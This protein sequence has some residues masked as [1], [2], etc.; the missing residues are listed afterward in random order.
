MANDHYIP[1][2]LIGRFST[3]TAGRSRQRKI[4]AL[5]RDKQSVARNGKA[6][7]YG[8][9]QD[10]YDLIM[11]QHAHMPQVVDKTWL[12][13]EN[14]LGT[15]LDVLRATTDRYAIDAHSWLT[16]L[17][18]FVASLFVRGPDF[19][20]RYEARPGMKEIY[21]HVAKQD[22]A[23]PR[24][25]TNMARLMEFQRLL[26]PIMAASW[27]VLHATGNIPFL[28]NDRG[29]TFYKP[30]GSAQIGWLI[31]VG[32]DVALAIQP[33]TVNSGRA[34]VVDTCIAHWRAILE[35]RA[36]SDEETAV[37]NRA[38]AGVASKFII[39][40][41]EESVSN[42][43]KPLRHKPLPAK[44]VYHNSPPPAVMRLHEHSWHYLLSEI[45][46]AAVDQRLIANLRHLKG[47]LLREQIISFFLTD[48]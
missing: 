46:L 14:H 5:E 6:E 48:H 39:G 35:H 38:I 31:P 36:I 30:N 16:V 4:W 18:P 32:Q 47:F 45:K 37:F 13:Y 19:N 27:T 9:E 44:Y 21:A 24:D 42:M 34:V 26:S 22:P 41:S 2:A 11:S 1:A 17:V 20:E 8:A 7:K 15:V 23:Y 12:A 3:E 25:N 40:P 10:F 29:Y 28:I 33:K 43:A